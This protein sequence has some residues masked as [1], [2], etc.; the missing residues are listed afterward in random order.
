VLT[1]LASLIAARGPSVIVPDW[2]SESDD[3]GRADLLGSLRF[4]R[5]SIDAGGGNPGALVLAGWSLGGTAAA[6]LTIHAR[7]LGVAVSHTVC[8]AGG[9]T[10]P[11]PISG[12]LL[13]GRL[14]G[15]RTRSGFT[16]MHGLADEIVPVAASRA[17]MQALELAGWSV[18]LAEL[19]TDH[20]GIVDESAVE[21]AHRVAALTR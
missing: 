19:P 10:T 21:V 5:D 9:F 11:D 15:G 6:G 18:D 17:F 2:N 1:P 8:L 20:L 7:R 3:G 13:T 12:K 16:L 4:V 14:P